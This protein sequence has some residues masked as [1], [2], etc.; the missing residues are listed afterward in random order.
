MY[1]DIIIEGIEEDEMC[2]LENLSLF[3]FVLVLCCMCV[4]YV[5]FCGCYQVWYIY[6]T[7]YTIPGMCYFLAIYR[8]EFE[9][10]F[11]VSSAKLRVV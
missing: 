7:V 9:N 3:L 6:Y 1:S 2:R 11:S 8:P 10:V 5:Y 4:Y